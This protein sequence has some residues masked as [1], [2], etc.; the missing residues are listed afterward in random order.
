MS[1]MNYAC[2]ARELAAD[3]HLLKLQCLRNKVLHTIHNFPRHALVHDLHMD[4]K[5]LS[6]SFGWSFPFRLSIV[7]FVS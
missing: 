7:N 5:I 1:V 3:T 4:L 6:W 2:P